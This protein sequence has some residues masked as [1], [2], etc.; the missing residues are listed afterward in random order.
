MHHSFRSAGC[1]A[2]APSKGE[3]VTLSSLPCTLC[4]VQLFLVTVCFVFDANPYDL[5][6]S[7]RHLLWEFTPYYPFV[8]RPYT[9]L[10][11]S[12]TVI[13]SAT[14]VTRDC[15][16]P[17]LIS[18]HFTISTAYSA[19]WISDY[20]CSM[21]V[22]SFWF[23]NR[24]KVHSSS[25]AVRRV[26]VCIP[27]P[28]HTQSCRWVAFWVRRPDVTPSTVAF[29]IF[30]GDDFANND[31]VAKLAMSPQSHLRKNFAQHMIFAHSLGH[32]DIHSL[33]VDVVLWGAL[34]AASSCWHRTLFY[35]SF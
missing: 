18:L 24:A 17:S 32:T 1:R 26:S 35:F 19:I 2:R 16:A 33:I 15:N 30:V 14:A 25:F 34:S 3:P 9:L 22:Q 21:F 8:E 7:T 29:R 10:F 31:D 12:L 27:I 4:F 5:H 20:R 11:G 13:R 6:L 28:K 23:R